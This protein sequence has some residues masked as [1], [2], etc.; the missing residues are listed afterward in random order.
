MGVVDDG[1]LDD[2]K[3]LVCRTA[4]VAEQAMLGENA[5][6]AYIPHCTCIETSGSKLVVRNTA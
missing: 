6:A 3:L 2:S 1:S 5:K 4:R